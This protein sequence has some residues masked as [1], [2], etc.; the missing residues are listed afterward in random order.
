MPSVQNS[1]D[2]CLNYCITFPCTSMANMNLRVF[3]N[4]PN[5]WKFRGDKS[6]LS[7]ACLSSYHRRTFSWSWSAWT[8]WQH[9]VTQQGD[10]FREFFHRVQSHFYARWLKLLKHATHSLSLS[11]C[12]FHAFGSLEEALKFTSRNSVLE[13]LV[14]C[15]RRQ[16]KGFFANGIC[17]L[18]HQRDS[19]PN[20]YGNFS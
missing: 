6:M 14:Q 7:A 15:F 10:A 9:T 11:P 5:I 8:T 4:G 17:H 12:D 20:V 18:V 1:S 19:H 13:V 3:V 16:L 2:C